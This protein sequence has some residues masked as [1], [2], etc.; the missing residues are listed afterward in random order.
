M[1]HHPVHTMYC[2]RL[3]CANANG[4]SIPWYPDS[5]DGPAWPYRDTCP[6]CGADLEMEPLP[7][8][9]EEDEHE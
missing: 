2:Q 5:I 1:R 3:A 9:D 6:L 4:V 8:P 7:E